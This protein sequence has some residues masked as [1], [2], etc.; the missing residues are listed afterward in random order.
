MPAYSGSLPPRLSRRRGRRWQARSSTERGELGFR[1][2]IARTLQQSSQAS[3]FRTETGVPGFA[4]TERRTSTW[5]S[6]ASRSSTG[7]GVLGFLA[8][9]LRTDWSASDASAS[10]T[11]TGVLGLSAAIQSTSSSSCKASRSNACS[12]ASDRSEWL[13]PGEDSPP[14]MKSRPGALWIQTPSGSHLATES[15]T[16]AFVITRLSRPAPTKLAMAWACRSVRGW[17]A[18]ASSGGPSGVAESRSPAE[19]TIGSAHPS[20]S[21]TRPATSNNVA[22]TAPPSD[23]EIHTAVNSPSAI[24]GVT[25]QRGGLSCPLSPE[26]SC[27]A[28]GSCAF[29]AERRRLYIAS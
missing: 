25:Y 22:S 26:R 28:D 5:S 4:A 20:R 3:T 7:T 27:G 12:M 14:L 29:W 18:T 2:T 6:E 10:N 21:A 11:G 1:A 9:P 16:G 13:P 17:S 19:T 23:H 15:D 24:R 8:T